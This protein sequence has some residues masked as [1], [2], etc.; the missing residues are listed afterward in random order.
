VNGAANGLI[1]CAQCHL[2]FDAVPR[3]LKILKSGRIEL[4]GLA[5]TQKYKNL[6]NKLVPWYAKIGSCNWPSEQLLELV[7]HLAPKKGKR[8]ADVLVSE[9]VTVGQARKKRIEKK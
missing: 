7:Y 6:H 3:L 4:M 2:Y 1:L 5:K 9:T 8:D